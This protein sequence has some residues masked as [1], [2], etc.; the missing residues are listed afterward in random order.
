MSWRIFAYDKTNYANKILDLYNKEV[1]FFL[2][3]LKMP[4]TYVVISLLIG[5]EAGMIL[6][7]KTH[8]EF[9][10]SDESGRNTF[11]FFFFLKGWGWGWLSDIWED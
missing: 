10:S 3:E 4:Q 1:D 8:T 5:R 7:S 2:Q 11:F 9:V 6:V